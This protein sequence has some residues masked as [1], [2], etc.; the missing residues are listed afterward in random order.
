MPPR[1]LLVPQK[2]ALLPP[3]TGNKPKPVYKVLNP[4][5]TPAETCMRQSGQDAQDAA[6]AS[7]SEEDEREIKYRR[8]EFAFARPPQPFLDPPAWEAILKR[9]EQVSRPGEGTDQ[10]GEQGETPDQRRQRLEREAQ[11][12][13]MAIRGRSSLRGRARGMARDR[14][15]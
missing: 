10:G 15:Y 11:Y 6:N 2:R 1:P 9:K 14:T 5:A 12:G 7:G 13:S 8:T 4:S 3:S